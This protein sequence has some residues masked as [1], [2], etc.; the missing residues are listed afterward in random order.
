MVWAIDTDPEARAIAAENAACNGV[1]DRLRIGHDLLTALP[2]FHIIVANLLAGALIELAADIAVCLEPGGVALGAG[3]LVAEAPAVRAAWR[4]AGLA[5]DGDIAD[6][7]WVA[8]AA[9]RSA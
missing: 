8:L 6:E 2:Q 1:A 5:D 9:R 3:V 7:G 4:A